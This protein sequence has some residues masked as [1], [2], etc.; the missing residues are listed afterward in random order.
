[1]VT[2][3]MPDAVRRGQAVYTPLTLRIY[4]AWVLGFSNHLVWRCPTRRLLEHYARHLSGR[5]LDAGV[6]T[7]CLLDH[8]TFPVAE[9]Q[10]TLLDL[11]SNT[12][13]FGSRRLSRYRPRT[14]LANLLEPIEF[15]ERFDSAGLNYVLHCLPGDLESKSVVFEHVKRGMNPGGVIFGSTLLSQGVTVSAAGRRLMRVYNRKGIFSNE[16]D[17]LAALEAVLRR[18]FVRHTIDVVGCAALFAGYC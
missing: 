12:L 5:H 17:S 6:G 16:R 13:E 9:P 1:M 4:D 11:N 7:A 8:S 3:S 10:L 14:Q 15:S 2:S 18:H